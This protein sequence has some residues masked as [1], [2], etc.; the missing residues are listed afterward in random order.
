MLSS[1][2]LER[3]LHRSIRVSFPLRHVRSRDRPHATAR[4]VVHQFRSQGV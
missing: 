2:R 3:Y 1:R 4:D